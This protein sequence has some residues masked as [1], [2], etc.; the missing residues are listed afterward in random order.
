MPPILVNDEAFRLGPANLWVFNKARAFLE[1]VLTGLN[2][3]LIFRAKKAG[4]AGNNITI[5]YV[6]PPG[7]NEPLSV[8]VVGTDIVVTLETDGTSTI[9]STAAEVRDAVNDHPGAASL[10]YAV[11]ASGNDGTG[12]VTALAE[13]PLAGGSDVLTER[14]L[15]ALGDETTVQTSVTASILTAH[16]TGT[17]PRDKVTSGGTFQILSGLKEI[18]LENFALGFPNAQLIEGADGKQ[19][20][21]FVVRAGE[22]LRQSRGVKM[23]L[24]RLLGGGQEETTDP[25]EI[26][27]VPTASP[28]DAQVDLVYSVETQ[29]I[30][31]VTFEAWPD[32]K[33]RTAFFGYEVL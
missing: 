15:G 21:D 12:V 20:L 28:V 24:R 9:V 11:L 10:V 32:S 22:S 1:T 16:T 4:T 30:I 19:R 26:L 5:T 8:A 2:N 14:F 27:T 17:Q 18:T 29:Q 25:H 33:G 7:N 3:D 13:T 6:D 23:Q 31:N